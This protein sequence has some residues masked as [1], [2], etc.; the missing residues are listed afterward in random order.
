LKQRRQKAML[1]KKPKDETKKKTSSMTDRIRFW[2]DKVIIGF[3]VLL[4]IC[5]VSSPHRFYLPDGVINILCIDAPNV[6]SLISLVNSG[7]N[8]N[9]WSLLWHRT[10]SYMLLNFGLL[11][12]SRARSSL[13][14]T[15]SAFKPQ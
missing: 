2:P 7:D 6:C 9:V 4:Y 8:R 3:D 12:L 1:K 15:G 5:C 10:H 13:T 11:A 14:T